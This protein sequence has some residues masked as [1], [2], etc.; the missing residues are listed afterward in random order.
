MDLS[1]DPNFLEEPKIGLFKSLTNS[2]SSLS[3]SMSVVVILEIR[4]FQKELVLTCNMEMKS[5]A[6]SVMI[7]PNICR[8]YLPMSKKL[9]ELPTS[10]RSQP[11]LAQS[12]PLSRFASRVGGGS[13]S[14]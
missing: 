4:L 14:R 8:K 10:R 3:I 12:V 7:L 6:S 11:P 9:F 13:A 5:S 2:E 1:P